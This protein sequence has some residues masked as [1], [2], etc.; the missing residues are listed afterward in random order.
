[1]ALIDTRREQ[2]FPVLSVA[3][4]EMARR[5]ASGE[6]RRFAP[7]EMV[8]DVGQRSVPMWLILD[9]S[10]EVRGRD[11]RG[12]GAPIVTETAGQF[13]G[14]VAQLAGR[15]A[16]AQGR[17]GPEGV[18]AVPFDAAHL[19]ALVIGSAE[20]GETIMRALILRR[21]GLI[22]A[23][24]VGSVLIG[25]PDSPDLIRLHGFL[26]RNGYPATVLDSRQAG[27]G[28]DLVER[29]GLAAADLP[30]MLCPNG[31]VLKRPSDAE[32]A[33][34]L[35]I[36]PD[37][38]PKR[39]YDVV[40]VGAGPAGLATAVYG[41][42]EG[43]SVLVLDQRAIGGQAGA[44]A[45]IENYLGFP[46]GISGQALAGRAFNQAQK[47]GAE[48]ALP[49]EV[50]RLDCGAEEPGVRP[51]FTLELGGCAT[52]R[53]RSVVVASG[54]RYR[55]LDLPN[56]ESLQGN[57]IHYWASPIEARL[58]EGEDVA[59]VGG[60]NSA[61]QATV[62][63][64][65]RVRRLH[66]ILRGTG[67]EASMSKYLIDRIGALPNVELHAHTEIV[68]LKGDNVQGLTGATC[69]H[70]QSGAERNHALRHLF[71]FIGADPN[72]AWLGGCV[73]TDPQGFIV[74]GSAAEPPSTGQ[75]PAFPLE[76]SR[77]GVFAIGDVRLGSTK[78]VSA[79][80]GEGAAVVAQI[81]EFLAGSG[82]GGTAGA[83]ARSHAPS[84]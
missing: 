18:N 32:A 38:D 25:H 62:F 40:I 30:V 70:R 84:L 81:H 63:L 3:Q 7:G 79:A 19:R 71:V 48:V 16:L 82:L 33:A 28:H 26:T 22:E 41:A 75:R 46:T 10:I 80:V 17:A 4:I 34:C 24:G 74:T 37:L 57:G 29:L 51:I 31:T 60:G 45:R 1:M 14:E 12:V 44:S 76:T 78:R 56:F 23:G 54:A 58:C 36:T 43:L 77:P 73:A 2:M 20:V 59:L 83:R 50:T 9:G 5:F 27:E 6:P 72:S 15:P 53:S 39:V 66:L 61:G 69:R 35:G 55:K 42:S 21:V 8:Y 64:A 47:F 11:G 67:L 49:L 13:S 52:V 68:R 65:P